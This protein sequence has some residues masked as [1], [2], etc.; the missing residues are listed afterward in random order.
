MARFAY[1]ALPQRD[2]AA[3]L[4]PLWIVAGISMIVGNVGA[5]A[6]ID[7]KRLLAYSGIAQLGYIVAAMAG[8]TALGL[9]YAIFYL[10]AYMFMNLGAFAVVALLSRE[11]DEGSRLASFAGLGHRQPVLAGLMTFFLLALAGLPPT[12]GF[13]G[14]IL[15]L[16]T[17]SEYRLRVAR[18]AADRRHGNQ[19][20]RVPQDRARDVRADGRSAE[21]RRASCRQARCRGSASPCA[22]SRRSDSAS[23]RSRRATCCRSSGKARARE[24]ATASF[25]AATARPPRK[26]YERR[27]RCASLVKTELSDAVTGARYEDVSVRHGRRQ[28]RRRGRLPR[29][30]CAGE[31]HRSEVRRVVGV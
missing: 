2:H 20:L 13:T 3:I 12:A 15:I 1:A 24:T 31:E 19:R 21:S 17:D 9:R 7:I 30:D 26:R 16:A 10:G 6:Q 25:Y 23:T 18:T 28:E 14:K 29:T 4:I 8:T 22:L 27:P 11:H 5:L